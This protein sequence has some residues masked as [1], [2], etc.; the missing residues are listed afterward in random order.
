MLLPPTAAIGRRSLDAVTLYVLA[1]TAVGGAVA[2]ALSWTLATSRLRRSTP[3]RVLAG[4]VGAG[5]YLATLTLAASLGVPT[6]PWSR[7]TGSTFILSTGLVALVLGWVIATDPFDLART[8]ERI[9]LSPADFA[10]LAPSDQAQLR[11]DSAE[12]KGAAGPGGAG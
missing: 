2:G 6:G 7:L 1:F 9:Y 8:T 3:L 10:S 5:I 4:A 11:L 12:S